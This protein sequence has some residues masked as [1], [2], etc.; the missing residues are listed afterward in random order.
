MATEMPRR[1][2]TRVGWCC[3]CR[4]D[5]K[6]TGRI[7]R[8]AA[9]VRRVQGKCQTCGMKAQNAL[10]T[11]AVDPAGAVPATTEPERTAA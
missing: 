5:R 6:I 3:R 2:A 11:P 8:S 7:V 4:T 1:V 9:G 10:F